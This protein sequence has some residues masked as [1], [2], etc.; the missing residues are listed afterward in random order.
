MVLVQLLVAAL[1]FSLKM[2]VDELFAVA[3]EERM[4][5]EPAQTPVGV[6]DVVTLVGVELMVTVWEAEFVHPLA[7]VAVTE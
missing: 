3:D 2:V 7:P 5:E 4:V 6:A 1:K